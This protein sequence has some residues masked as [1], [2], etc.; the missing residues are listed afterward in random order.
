MLS[1]CSAH[2]YL[3]PEWVE[4]HAWA[5]EKD[6]LQKLCPQ[7]I[8]CKQSDKQYENNLNALVAFKKLVYNLF[9][10]NKFK[11]RILKCFIRIHHPL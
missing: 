8:D 7:Q 2:Q 11:V 9:D 4:P 1:T 6:P 10:R 5:G 3:N